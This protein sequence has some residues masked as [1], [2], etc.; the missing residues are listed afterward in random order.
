MKFIGFGG[1]VYY[2]YFLLAA[3]LTKVLKEDIFGFGKSF[4]ILNDL[5]ISKHKFLILFLNY[6]SEFFFGLIINLGLYYL[7]KKDIKRKMKYEKM[8]NNDITDINKSHNDKKKKKKSK[9]EMELISKEKDIDTVASVMNGNNLINDERISAHLT[10]L[11]S[12]K[13]EEIDNKLDTTDN[14]HTVPKKYELI[15]NNIFEDITDS[16]INSMILSC[17]LLIV[18]DV[19]VKWI[20]SYFNNDINL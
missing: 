5:R 20:F 3:T 6:F 2:Y 15:H 18:N 14:S 7:E 9:Q 11:I 12:K 17:F 1:W 13:S 16:S 4:Q 8:E 10:L 19:V